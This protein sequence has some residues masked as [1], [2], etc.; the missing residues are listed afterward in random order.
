MYSHEALFTQITPLPPAPNSPLQAF[1]GSFVGHCFSQADPA[2]PALHSQKPL[3][4]TPREL[5]IVEHP[6]PG[7]QPDEPGQI[8]VQEGGPKYPA[9]Q[10]S[11]VSEQFFPPNPV[12]QAQ[13]ASSVHSP[14][15][16]QT[17]TPSSSRLSPHGTLSQ[18]T[19]DGTNCPTCAGR[20]VATGVC[21]QGLCECRGDDG[22]ENNPNPNPTCLAIPD[23]EYFSVSPALPVF[24]K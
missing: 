6:T 16:L 3:W 5:Q 8:L 4:Q 15:P 2:K 7:V 22:A 21:E 24:S 1:I 12:L 19:V 11:A 23:P 17:W 14:F 9:W 20:S 10:V 18:S 13:C